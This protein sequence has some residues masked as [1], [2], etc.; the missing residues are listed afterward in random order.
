MKQYKLVD[1]Y[2]RITS[3]TFKNDKNTLLMK[4]KDLP[5]SIQT[6][7]V[8]TEFDLAKSWCDFAKQALVGEYAEAN[9][10]CW[11]GH[12]QQFGRVMLEL[13]RMSRDKAQAQRIAAF[14]MIPDLE[15][16]TFI[17]EPSG[18]EDRTF[19]RLWFA[20]IGHPE[21]QHPRIANIEMDTF[22]YWGYLIGVATGKVN[23]EMYK[24]SIL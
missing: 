9:M 13:M 1:N 23:S 7:D 21:F 3:Y 2:S 24:L 5:D 16:F 8:K 19:Y 22:N 14:E 18:T 10:T 12:Y 6:R 20:F 4:L 11:E 17:A 15:N